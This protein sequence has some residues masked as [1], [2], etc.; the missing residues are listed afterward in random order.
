[1]GWEIRNGRAYYYRKAREG[2]RVRSKYV[3]GGIVGQMYSEIDQ[4][5]QQERTA[6]C[7]AQR[8]TRQAEAEIE[9]QLKLME[10][11]LGTIIEAALY[12]SGYHKHKGQWRKKRHEKKA[13]TG[14]EI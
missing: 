7:D 1:M 10:A 4:E 2:G 14:K 6:L 3:G 11:A 8:A 5:E 12:A 9:Q 13:T